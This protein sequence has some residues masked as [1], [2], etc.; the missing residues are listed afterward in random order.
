MQ[1]TQ[2]SN[3]EPTKSPF[4]KKGLRME[5]PRMLDTYR[6]Y[7][8]FK[9]Q[10]PES[11]YEYLITTMTSHAIIKGLLNPFIRIKTMCQCDTAP[12]RQGLFHQLKG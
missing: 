1:F 2:I 12:N 8:I 5:E 3:D 7:Q 4:A 6:P 10:F 11:H 9:K